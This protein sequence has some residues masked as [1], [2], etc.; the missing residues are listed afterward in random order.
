MHL[1]RLRKKSGRRW[2]RATVSSSKTGRIAFQDLL[3]EQVGVLT[4]P[5]W[6]SIL[7]H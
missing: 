5:D 2:F 4:K 3:G 6:V 1:L 7:Y